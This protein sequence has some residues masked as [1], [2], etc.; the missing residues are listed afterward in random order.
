M[1]LLKLLMDSFGMEMS[2][3]EL[4]LFFAFLEETEQLMKLF[5]KTP[6]NLYR[7]NRNNL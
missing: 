6:L 2:D 4:K 5:C 1:L 3:G 7:L